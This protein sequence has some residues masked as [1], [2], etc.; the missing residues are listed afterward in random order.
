MRTLYGGA[1]AAPDGRPMPHAPTGAVGLLASVATL[2]EVSLA[3]QLGA[4]ILD[5]KD[6]AAGALGAW[7]PVLLPE[8][9]RLVAGRV[10]VSAT[11]GDLPMEP[12]QLRDAARVTAAAG[13]DIV[14]LGFFGGAGQRAVLE[15]L[16]PLARS[17]VRLVSVLMA[18]R[19]PDLDL[20]PLLARAG[21]FGVMLDTA[22]KS[23]G[24]LRRHLDPVRL[25][26][27]VAS[28]RA[29]GLVSG[30][31]GSLRVADIAPLGRLR[32]DYL[33][34]RGALCGGDRTAGLDAGAM[35]AVRRAVNETCRFPAL[36]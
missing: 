15:A 8:A 29:H 35:A 7:D 13:V 30:L 6:P 19:E 27:F 22:E 12:K 1:E 32:P 2:E 5:L 36:A 25:A 16:A 23:A 3:L 9:V 24:G 20:T 21:F 4:D 28:A 31:A 11:V 14:K 18:D 34:F 17:G 10:P 33:G 26:A